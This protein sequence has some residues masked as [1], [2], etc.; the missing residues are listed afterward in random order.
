MPLVGI[1][2]KLGFP[3]FVV[4][5]IERQQ[6]RYSKGRSDISV[7]TLIAPAYQRRLKG[8]IDYTEDVSDR[9]SAFIGTAV[10]KELE[11][12]EGPGDVIEE[13]F[14]YRAK[15]VAGEKVV[16]GQADLLTTIDGERWLIDHKT[17][18]VWAAIFGGKK[19]WEQQLNLLRFLAAQK[20]VQT[21]DPSYLATRLAIYCYFTDFVAAKAGQDDYPK[22]PMVVMEVPVWPLEEAGLFLTERVEAHFAQ[23]PAPCSDEERW[24]T[25]EQFAVMKVGRKSAIKLHEVREEAEQMAKDKGKDHF[26]EIRPRTYRRCA[27]YCPVAHGCPHHNAPNEGSF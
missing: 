13:R 22:A 19:E 14:F 27:S 24:A 26:V 25:P 12:G 21:N 8:E 4:R 5:A 11:S 17:V 2:N 1:T 3:D 10:H 20:A 23:E 9:V 6:G 15:T 7:T 18:K 16:S